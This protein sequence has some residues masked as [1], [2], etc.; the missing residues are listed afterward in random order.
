MM[1]PMMVS[2]QDAMYHQ[3]PNC[4]PPAAAA[5]HPYHQAVRPYY[6]S[7][8]TAAPSTTYHHQQPASIHGMHPQDSAFAPSLQQ[9]Q[10][11]QHLLMTIPSP[12]EN[13]SQHPLPGTLNAGGG[14]GGEG[15]PQGT[16]C[17]QELEQAHQS[18]SPPNTSATG[19][20]TTMISTVGGIGSV[21][22]HPPPQG[23]NI[24]VHH[25]PPLQQPP[26]MT[27]YPS[28]QV[29]IPVSTMSY[30]YNYPQQQQQQSMY[31]IVSQPPPPTY[32][33]GHSLA[34]HNNHHHP[35]AATVQY[36]HFGLGTAVATSTPPQQQ[37]AIATIDP[38]ANN[39]FSHVNLDHDD[40]A[41]TSVQPQHHLDGGG[42][43][44]ID[45]L[46]LVSSDKRS[47]SATSMNQA[48]GGGN[49]A[50]CA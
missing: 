23:G 5:A 42:G 25:P 10:H 22:Q 15:L 28:N 43:D 40:S 16:A 1:V 32:T 29:G 24:M 48:V 44:N 17:V 8:S 18:Q 21:H 46:L 12:A 35:N 45:Q 49:L 2:P 20:D 34:P 3:G 41:I 36:Q 39:S 19:T 27:M 50:H 9:I 47:T 26:M 30:G 31:Q 37:Y 11:Q 14:G 38:P 6:S 7:K 33:A 13:A 4:V